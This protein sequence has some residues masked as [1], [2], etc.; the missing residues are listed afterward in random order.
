MAVVIPCASNSYC[1]SITSYVQLQI[2]PKITIKWLLMY[3]QLQIK[4]MSK[5]KL[6]YI[7]FALVLQSSTS[8]CISCP[9]KLI[10]IPSTVINT[11][12]NAYFVYENVLVTDTLKWSLHQS[13][14]FCNTMLLN[15]CSVWHHALPSSHIT[16]YV[17]LLTTNQASWLLKWSFHC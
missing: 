10:F 9:T 2:K 3:I 12:I 6:R 7:R 11:R 15:L 13:I 14:L 1:K 17:G 16:T 5:L 4:P 8:W